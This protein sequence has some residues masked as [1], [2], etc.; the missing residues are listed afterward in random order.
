MLH[1]PPGPCASLA[2]APLLSADPASHR[3][4]LSLRLR[5]G[6][7]DPT[8]EGAADSEA[9]GAPEEKE[10]VFVDPPAGGWAPESEE[11][12]GYDA[13]TD[14]TR[15]GD[16]GAVVGDGQVDYYKFSMTPPKF[17]EGVDL[18]EEY[19]GQKGEIDYIA[20]DTYIGRWGWTALHRAATQGDAETLETMLKMGGDP[21]AFTKNRWTVLH[22][23]A[24][25]G[26]VG[27]IKLLVEAGANVSAVNGGGWTPLHFAAASGQNPA[28]E[29]LLSL[30]G[31]DRHARDNYGDTALDKVHRC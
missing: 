19:S 4:T 31:V 30:P 17:A 11:E 2:I 28:V 29:Y 12:L 9:G 15:I 21:N 1:H 8:A 16:D 3:V 5:G 7:V 14:G 27:C 23:A 26:N 18:N 24:Q 6:L 20:R 25:W 22:E 10:E 13:E